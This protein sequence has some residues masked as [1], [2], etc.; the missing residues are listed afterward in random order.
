MK[1]MKESD[2][3]NII[4]KRHKTHLPPVE[5]ASGPTSQRTEQQAKEQGKRKKK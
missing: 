5:E 2:D 3:E 1:R 4:L